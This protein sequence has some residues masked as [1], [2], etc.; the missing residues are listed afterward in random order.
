MNTTNFPDLMTVK[1]RYKLPE[2]N[3]SQKTEVVVV[4]KRSPSASN[5]FNFAAAVAMYAQILRNSEFKEKSTYND[6]IELAKK[7]L[8]NDDQ[9]YRREFVRLVETTKGLGTF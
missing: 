2:K 8:G 1:L 7:G 4:D 3:T 5:D 6:V 9:G